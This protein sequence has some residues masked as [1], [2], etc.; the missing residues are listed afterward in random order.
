[1]P[2]CGGCAPGM[3]ASTRVR[4][5]RAPSPWAGTPSAVPR[6]LVP[7]TGIVPAPTVGHRL[8]LDLFWGALASRR[9]HLA[10]AQ[11]HAVCFSLVVDETPTT[12]T[13]TV[14]LPLD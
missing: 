9:N 7:N 11:T 10:N 14:V 8:W 1:M 4:Y 13:G 12:A 6:A 3:G 2:S 5:A